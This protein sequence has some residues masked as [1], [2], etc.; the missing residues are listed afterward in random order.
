MSINMD[1]LNCVGIHCFSETHDCL[2]LKQNSFNYILQNFTKV[3]SR[4]SLSLSDSNSN[5]Q[6]KGHFIR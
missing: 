1:P 3:Y 5:S 6:L 2:E 4:P